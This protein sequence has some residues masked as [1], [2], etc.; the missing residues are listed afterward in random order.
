MDCESNSSDILFPM[1]AGIPKLSSPL[2]YK[3]ADAYDWTYH[4]FLN[5]FY[6]KSAQE[7]NH[8]ISYKQNIPVYDDNDTQKPQ[9]MSALDEKDVLAQLTQRFLTLEKSELHDI[10]KSGFEMVQN[11]I[12]E[13]SNSNPFSF[14]QPGPSCVNE[15]YDSC[16]DYIGLDYVK[17]STTKPFDSDR[18]FDNQLGHHQFTLETS[19][20]TPPFL[21][22]LSSVSSDK[23]LPPLP[24]L[25]NHHSQISNPHDSNDLPSNLKSNGLARLKL[26]MANSFQK[27]PQPEK[28]PKS[29]LQSTKKKVTRALQK[30][31]HVS[32]K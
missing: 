24:V 8:F 27:K 22:T 19:P 29:L 14:T 5:T 15:H 1:D 25:D 17:E 7:L 16:N 10:L 21:A 28:Q 26:K 30:I 18:I 4:D 20:A 32:K 11:H 3:V 9:K 6:D 31:L 2:D 12:Q 13:N 23:P